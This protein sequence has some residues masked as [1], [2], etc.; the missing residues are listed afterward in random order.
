MRFCGDFP[1]LAELAGPEQRP[2]AHGVAREG[3]QTPLLA[4]DDADRGADDEARLPGRRHGLEQRPARGDD[5]LDEA[6]AFA[7][8]EG[9]LDPVRGPVALRPVADHEEGQAAGEGGRRG[10][11]DA[12]EHRRREADGVR[13]VLAHEGGDPLPQRREEIGARL[14]AVLVEVVARTATRAEHEVALEVGRLDQRLPQ[15]GVGHAG[16]AAT[17]TWRASASSSSAVAEPASEV[18]NEPSAKWTSIHSRP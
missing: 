4:V 3:V 17:R 12:A 2:Q 15:L 9:A 1:R 7:G 8:L 5:V 16:R 14:E 6:D 10:Q 11:D 13:L 18:T